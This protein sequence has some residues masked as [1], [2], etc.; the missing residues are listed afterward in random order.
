MTVMRGCGAKPIRNVRPL[1]GG[2][3]RLPPVRAQ[4]L[5]EH[6][7]LRLERVLGALPANLHEQAVDQEAHPSDAQH[8]RKEKREHDLRGQA[9]PEWTPGI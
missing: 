9:L 2:R 6:A 4:D 3:I 1:K 7:G 5:G 8:G